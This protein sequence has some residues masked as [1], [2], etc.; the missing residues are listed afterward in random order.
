MCGVTLSDEYWLA[1]QVLGFTREEIDQMI[2]TGFEGSFLSWPER[3]A[4]A[5][6][7]RAD[8]AAIG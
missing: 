7:V 3:R 8:L 6:R 4:L 2:L 5:D 1:H